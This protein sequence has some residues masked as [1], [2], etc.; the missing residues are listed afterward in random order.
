MVQKIHE[1]GLIYRDIKP[2][3]FLVDRATGTHLYLI[4]F[5]MAKWWWRDPQTKQHIP[6]R[7]RKSLSG[8]ARYMSVNTHLGRE[9]SRR[10]DLESLGHVFFYFLRGTL[11]W[12]GLRAATN[13]EKHERIGSK[14]QCTTIAELG[15]GHSPEFQRYLEYCRSMTFDQNP[16][17]S[18]LIGLMK[19][20]L[21]R[22]NKKCL[23]NGVN[24]YGPL[25]YDWLRV[26]SRVSNSAGTFSSITVDQKKKNNGEKRVIDSST[27]AIHYYNSNHHQEKDPLL[28]RDSQTRSP[29]P[30]PTTDTRLRPSTSGTKLQSTKAVYDGEDL[31]MILSASRSKLQTGSSLPQVQGRQQQS[32]QQEQRK[33]RPWYRRLFCL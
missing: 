5:G 3:N 11:P 4:D 16:D 30:Q 15:T 17:Y 21:V 29:P 33:R 28:H 10:D 6:Y 24:G 7:E 22:E 1:R 8:T 13:K 32:Q 25:A 19:D 20:V 26:P 31:K 23:N 27:R 9:Q 14:K 12:Q 2:D 18:R